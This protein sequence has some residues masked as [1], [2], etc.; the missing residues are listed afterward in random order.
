MFRANKNS[1]MWYSKNRSSG[2][3]LFFRVKFGVP[4]DQVC[5]NDIPGPLLVRD[6]EKKLDFLD[7]L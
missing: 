3:R 7:E 1:F 5:R 4:I 6:R 2:T